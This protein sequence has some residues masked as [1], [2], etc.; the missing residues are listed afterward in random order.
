LEQNGKEEKRKRRRP[1]RAS[2]RHLLCYLLKA[3]PFSQSLKRLAAA[4]VFRALPTQ[5]IQLQR[6]STQAKQSAAAR[7]A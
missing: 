6:G 7:L 2:H 4:A 1:G 3:V 5:R